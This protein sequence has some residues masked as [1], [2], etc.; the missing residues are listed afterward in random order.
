M[1][2]RVEKLHAAYGNVHVLNGVTFDVRAGE[3]VTILGRNGS[4]RSTA[5]KTIMGLVE[6]LSGSVRYADVELAGASPHTIAR[7]GIG[8][9]PEDRQIFRN[10]TVAENLALGSKTAAA[11]CPT[12]KTDELLD[13]FPRLRERLKIQ[14]GHLSG[15][16]QQM[17]TLFRTLLGNPGVILID[18]PTEGLAPK[19]IDAVAEC[20]V[21]MKR[22]GLA[23]LLLEQKMSMALRLTDRF[24]IMGRGE[25]VFAGTP[26]EFEAADE[27]RKRWISPDPG[28][29]G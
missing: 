5:C 17:L 20:I 19:I 28:G 26:A 14:A 10:L 8:Y 2:L 6:P 21:E 4:G 16:E 27:T 24:L 3:I 13:V 29:H 18:E 7:R 25:I 11:G 23:V 12:W 15:G 9:V 22:R 1:T